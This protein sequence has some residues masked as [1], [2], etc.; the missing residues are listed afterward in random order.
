MCGCDTDK[1][2]PDARALVCPG[3]G[4]H[5]VGACC[6]DARMRCVRHPGARLLRAPA[7]WQ[8]CVA[9]EQAWWCPGGHLARGDRAAHLAGCERV[10]AKRETLAGVSA[11]TRVP[12]V[13]H[14]RTTVADGALGV[15]C[16]L[17]F[18]NGN[19]AAVE[20]ATFL[21][22]RP[23]ALA[24]TLS[25]ANVATTFWCAVRGEGAVE[26]AALPTVNAWLAGPTRALSTAWSTTPWSSPPAPA[27]TIAVLAG[28]PL[29]ARPGA[30]CGATAQAGP[31]SAPSTPASTAAAGSATP[32]P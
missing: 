21:N 9:A 20:C 18:Q 1:M 6:Q 27:S 14:A 12:T 28:A 3:G 10:A 29:S 23:A 2:R 17:T 30:G 11:L 13:G 4:G 16:V 8:A 5:W 25:D 7:L 26:V 31:G 22:A 15:A 32:G 24:I 19:L